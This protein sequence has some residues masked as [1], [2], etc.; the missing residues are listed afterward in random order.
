MTCVG[1]ILF[2]LNSFMFYGHNK[3]LF[4]S[5]VFKH[6]SEKKNKLKKL[7]IVLIVLFVLILTIHCAVWL[8]FTQI[9]I[10]KLII[11]SRSNLICIQSRKIYFI[12]CRYY[13]SVL[14][15]FSKK[16]KII[17]KYKHDRHSIFF[18]YQTIN[19]FDLPDT[20][21]IN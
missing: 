20:V 16:K 13:V 2:R 21:N 4:F 6:L 19:R 10:M 11:S 5:I 12:S 9:S 7:K 1:F 17:C 8:V 15:S 14:F 18:F 3:V